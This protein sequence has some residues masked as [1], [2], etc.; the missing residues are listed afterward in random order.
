M[1]G[2]LLLTVLPGPFGAGGYAASLVVLTFG[3]AMFQAASMT[4]IMQTTASENRGVTSALVG[5]ARNM[6]LIWG[7]SAMAAV[8]AMGPR[9]AGATG[10]GAGN[11]T[12]LI[13]TFALSAGLADLAL[14]ATF[15]VNRR[16]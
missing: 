6:G 13:A 10:F 9:I 12:G 16:A 11:G 1:L 15:W 14:A 3:Y 8:Y 5:L 4:A 7:A 2:A